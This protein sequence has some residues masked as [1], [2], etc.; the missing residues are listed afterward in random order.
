MGK[1]DTFMPMKGQVRCLIS[2]SFLLAVSR[3][4][5]KQQQQN[6]VILSQDPAFTSKSRFFFS[7]TVKGLTAVKN[8]GRVP[9]VILW[10][11]HPKLLGIYR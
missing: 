8:R 6:H 2:F 3:T 9:L 11:G 5:K 7:R 4:V 1:Y 10:R